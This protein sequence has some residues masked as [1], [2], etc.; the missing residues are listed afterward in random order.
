[1]GCNIQL[2]FY[3]SK[4]ASDPILVKALLNEKETTLPVPTNQYPYYKWDDL[5]AYYLKKL[6]EF[7]KDE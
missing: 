3:H 2:V 4:K 1:M 5:R 7:E 6:E